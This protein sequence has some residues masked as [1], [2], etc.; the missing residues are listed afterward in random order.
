VGDDTFMAFIRGVV[1]P[2]LKEVPGIGDAAVK[3]LAAGEG[4]EKITNTY[5]LIGKVSGE[6]ER[7]S[8]LYFR[9]ILLSRSSSFLSLMSYV[10]LFSI[11]SLSF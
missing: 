2:N 3:K 7:A 4:D 11:Y 5:Q 6:E 8:R 9:I 1:T 10:L